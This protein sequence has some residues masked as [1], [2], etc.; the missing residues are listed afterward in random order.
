MPWKS[1]NA[2]NWALNLPQGSW[3]LNTDKHNID[4]GLP[5]SPE[6]GPCDQVWALLTVAPSVGMECLAHHVLQK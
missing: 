5:L 1:V 2:T 3:L 6:I 4:L